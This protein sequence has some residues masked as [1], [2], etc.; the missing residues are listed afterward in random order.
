MA[1]RFR[2]PALHF[3]TG[4]YT[5]ASA[6]VST[7]WIDVQLLWG[8]QPLEARF[9]L[10]F[11]EAEGTGCTIYWPRRRKKKK[12][13]EISAQLRRKSE[14]GGWEIWVK[15]SKNL[16]EKHGCPTT[17]SMKQCL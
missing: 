13:R 12:R 14:G 10:S 2:R 9:F 3:W 1:G 6:D 17:S 11:K 15:V 8:K 4:E 16:E 5:G 7:G